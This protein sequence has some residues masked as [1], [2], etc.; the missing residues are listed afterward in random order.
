MITRAHKPAQPIWPTSW[1]ESVPDVCGGRNSVLVQYATEPEA[2]QG[3]LVTGFSCYVSGIRR[4][5]L[6]V[7]IHQSSS[8]VDPRYWMDFGSRE[9]AGDYLYFEAA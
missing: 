5:V 9:A 6:L 3:I 1:R 7:F 2:E 8:L 4:A